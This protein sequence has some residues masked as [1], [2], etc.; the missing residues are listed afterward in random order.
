[1]EY[2]GSNECAEPLEF[3]L[4]LLHRETDHFCD[5]IYIVASSGNYKF[6]SQRG[7]V[8]FVV[9]LTLDKLFSYM[10]TFFTWRR[11]QPVYHVVPLVRL[12]AFPFG[13]LHQFTREP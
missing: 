9:H 12:R 5:F 3:I 1:M 4:H 10:G 2:F 13:T 8:E 7:R 6:N 11:Y